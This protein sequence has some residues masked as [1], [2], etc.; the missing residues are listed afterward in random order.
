MAD[1]Y[2][3]D[4]LLKMGAKPAEGARAPSAAGSAS[5]S[6]G[7]SLDEVLAAGGKPATKASPDVSSGR[8]AGGTRRRNEGMGGAPKGYIPREPDALEAPLRF[9]TGMDGAQQV[10]Q[11]LGR[12]YAAGK[13]TVQQGTGPLNWENY[14]KVVTAPFTGGASEVNGGLADVA[15]GVGRVYAPTAL[16]GLATGLARN[17]LP[18]LKTIGSAVAAGL[19]VPAV[20]TGAEAIGL[21]PGTAQGLSD[22]AGVGVG[23]AVYN[24]LPKPWMH[25]EVHPAAKLL[26]LH[27]VKP[28]E[29]D[30]ANQVAP[31]AYDELRKVAP[32]LF[33]LD[34]QKQSGGTQGDFTQRV[35][36]KLGEAK[37]AVMSRFEQRIA[38]FKNKATNGNDLATVVANAS[39]PNKIGGDRSR[40]AQ[41]L[42]SAYENRYVPLEE[43]R[44]DLIRVNAETDAYHKLSQDAKGLKER[45]DVNDIGTMVKLGKVLRD[46]IY[47][48][49]D[50]EAGGANAAEEMRRYGALIDE[51]AKVGDLIVPAQ[52][53]LPLTAVKIAREGAK[54]ATEYMAGLRLSA[55]RGALRAIG[56]PDTVD[57]R[58]MDALRNYKGAPPPVPARTSSMPEP[59]IRG[60]LGPARGNLPTPSTGTPII[61]PSPQPDPATMNPQMPPTLPPNYRGQSFPLPAALTPQGSGTS[62]IVREFDRGLLQRPDPSTA[63]ILRQWLARG[64]GRH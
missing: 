15:E 14:K 13:Q 19:T 4:E 50:T 46:K 22:V 29:T 28:A 31:R 16:T 62:D 5:S 57:M 6:T 40:F 44:T 10:A 53:G 21:Q 18:R 23:A 45:K 52:M 42:I 9:V 48:M 2:T 64:G 58:V 27:G 38:P 49:V 51:Q 30:Y 34:V 39:V 7:Y 3:L 25:G 36:D 1:G 24:A 32:E 35:Y 54:S 61:T 43:L 37:K 56:H 17:T 26:D 11:G 60:L 8:T 59:V 55:A 41:D 12:I 63:E 33:D 47:E 20:R